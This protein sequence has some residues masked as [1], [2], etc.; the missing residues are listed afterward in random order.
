ML[1]HLII[2]DT[3]EWRHA[4]GLCLDEQLFML[5]MIPHFYCI[6]LNIDRPKET[7]E[8]KKL[9]DFSDLCT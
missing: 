8:N 1:L 7:V 9:T 3:E 6:S 4:V 5:S 2:C